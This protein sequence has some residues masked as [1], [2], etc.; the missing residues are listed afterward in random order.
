MKLLILKVGGIATTWIKWIISLYILIWLLVKTNWKTV[1]L[2]ITVSSVAK[3]KT[4][5]IKYKLTT[6]DNNFILILKWNFSKNNVSVLLT[7]ITIYNLYRHLQI[8]HILFFSLLIL[9][10]NLLISMIT[11][12]ICYD[13][14]KYKHPVLK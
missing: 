14:R 5:S 2:V 10:R 6:N 11:L 13:I 1:K 9:L 7:H 3:I 12:L 4:N 8:A